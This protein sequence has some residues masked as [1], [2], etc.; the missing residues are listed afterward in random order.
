[1]E[2]DVGLPMLAEAEQIRASKWQTVLLLGNPATIAAAREW[3]EGVWDLGRIARG[4]DVVSTEYVALY[5]E[6]GRRR[7]MFYVA[8]RLDLG[9]VGGD[10]PRSDSYRR[11]LNG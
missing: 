6:T 1:M 10:L 5:E 4:R 2:T 7:D 9:I 3:Q 11:R 8:A